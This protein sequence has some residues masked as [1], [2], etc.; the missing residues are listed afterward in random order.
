LVRRE[1]ESSEAFKN[2]NNEQ[3]KRKQE[4]EVRIQEHEDKQAK[5]Q[6]SMLE[7]NKKE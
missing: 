7:M 5:R 2:R 6:Q 4:L 3:L 1:S